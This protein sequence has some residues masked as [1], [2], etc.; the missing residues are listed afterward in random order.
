MNVN[1]PA[2]EIPW[3]STGHTF[4]GLFRIHHHMNVLVL[5]KGLGAACTSLGEG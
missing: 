2:W 1:S 3:R 5:P 4:W